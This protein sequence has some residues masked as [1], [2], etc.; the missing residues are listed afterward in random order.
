MSLL[1]L[2]L[3]RLTRGRANTE[4]ENQFSEVG[5]YSNLYCPNLKK[6]QA[7][8]LTG[9]FCLGKGEGISLGH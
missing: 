6:K 3:Q 7:G 8:F 1:I 2:Q 4:A 5:Q 9:F